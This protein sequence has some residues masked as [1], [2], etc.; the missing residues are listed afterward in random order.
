MAH[1]SITAYIKRSIIRRNVEESE[2][3]SAAISFIP[4]LFAM[5]VFLTFFIDLGTYIYIYSATDTA[6]YQL[7]K[8]VTQDMTLTEERLTQIAQGTSSAFTYKNGTL[9]VEK[10]VTLPMSQQYDHHLPT[11]GDF[12]VRDSNAV[13]RLCMVTVSYTY[14]P[15]TPAGA[16]MAENDGAIHLASSYV[17]TIDATSSESDAGVSK[18]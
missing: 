10:E 7:C 4:F 12:A 17:G 6:A 18:W 5:L 14:K 15:A 3:G 1:A 16:L 2:N 13:Y 9:T 8:Q 11:S